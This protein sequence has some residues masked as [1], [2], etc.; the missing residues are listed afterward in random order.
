MTLLHNMEET[1]DTSFCTCMLHY[2][3]VN[4]SRR[5]RHKAVTHRHYD[6]ASLSTFHRVFITMCIILALC[7]GDHGQ[8][9]YEQERIFL[10][11][12][13]GI[14]EQ[15]QGEFIKL[16]VYPKASPNFGCDGQ[17]VLKISFAGPYRMARFFLDYY[18][19]PRNW[20]LDISDSPGGD[21][22]GGDGDLTSNMAE[23]QI[24]DKQMR[25]YSNGL[26]GYT[27]ETLNGGLLLKIVDDVVEAGTKLKLEIADEKVRWNNRENSKGVM[28][29]R[30][31]FMLNGQTP[32]YGEMDH[33][34]YVGLNR[35]PS[36]TSRTG[37][38][39]CRATIIMLSERDPEP[40]TESASLLLVSRA[41]EP[42]VSTGNTEINQCN[43]GRHNCR[44]NE[45]CTQT[46]K[47]FRCSCIHGYNRQGITCRDVDEC[48]VKSG[49][50]VHT[51]INTLGSY[52]CGCYFGFTLHIEGK[53]CLDKDECASGEHRCQHEC[54]NTIGSYECAC[55]KGMYLNE[56][57]RTC[58]NDAGCLNPDLDCA[59]YCVDVAN[60]QSICQC[61]PGYL[62]SG[63]KNC[64]PTCLLGNGGCQHVCTDSPIGPLCSCH[65]KY[66]L[67]TDGRTC[68]E[69]YDDPDDYSSTSAL[70]ADEVLGPRHNGASLSGIETCGLNNGG[71]DRECED[72]PTG[73]QCSCPEGFDLLAD[74]R[75]CNDRDEC[76]V[77]NGG[78]SHMCTNRLG[79]Y[80]CTCPRGYKL[81]SE[82][83]TCEDV[84]ECSMN[85]TCDHTCVNLPG[86]FRC[87]CDAGFQAYG[88]THC[89]DVDECSINN[90]GCQHGC[91]NTQ[92]SYECYCREGFK[93]HPNKKDCIAA[94]RCLPLRT[95]A[96][97][98]LQCETEGTDEVC[99]L[100]CESNSHFTASGQG[101][102]NYQCGESTHFEWTHGATNDT[103][104]SCSASVDVPMVS[105]KARLFFSTS[106]CELQRRVTRQLSKTINQKL[107][108]GGCRRDCE[109]S[110][111]N[112]SCDQQPVARR[113]RQAGRLSSSSSSIT[114]VA[115]SG[116]L[117]T[118]YVE[119]VIKAR[120]N[121]VT[122]R[123]DLECV[124]K[125]SERKMKR[126]ITKL[127]KAIERDHFV[128]Q[129]DG[130]EYEMSRNLNVTDVSEASCPLGHVMID[131]GRCVACSMGTYYH[132]SSGG[133][134]PC[135][136]GSYQ[137]EEGQLECRRC[138]Q[139]DQQ[140]DV[141]GAR[142]ITE[143][144]G[145]CRPGEYSV[146]GFQPCDSCPVGSY[147]PESGRTH[148]LPCKGGL[149]TR[150]HGSTSFADCLAKEHCG[151]GT[152]Y[153]VTTHSCERCPR[154][155]YQPHPA[156]NYCIRCPGN[157]TT[158]EN[159]VAD[160]DQCKDTTCR[161][162]IGQYV[163]Y[164]ETPN[165][166]GDYPANVDCTWHIKPPRGRKVIFV[167]SEIFLRKEDQC[168]DIVVIR[169]TASPYSTT[170]F[171]TCE[172]VTRPIAFLAQ[173]KR[174][175]IRFTT[176]AAHAAKG[177][178][179]HYSMY[180]ETYEDL[181]KD[182]VGD[183]RLYESEYH[184]EILKNKEVLAALLEIIAHPEI[185][186]NYRLEE[187]RSILPRSF[188]KLLRN[189][190]ARFLYPEEMYP[191]GYKDPLVTAS[192]WD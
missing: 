148:C 78:C 68:V 149:L 182:I 41:Q 95:P 15:G 147:Q 150:S 26:S 141:T 45:A 163:G 115:G 142:H 52:Q 27:S 73:V 169:K 143:C 50:C 79:T 157:T 151:P 42:V 75:T 122:S 110:F 49:G 74:G 146:D 56:D 186:D 64:I 133:C 6:P 152:Y 91:H 94:I 170:S 5:L 57:G 168:G 159:G 109:V 171:E 164:I 32:E 140:Y 69:A 103:L 184:Q 84:N 66:N 55:P 22:M 35:V 120:L 53:D 131:A 104:P 33:D 130:N 155:W 138:P 38:G 114:D 161:A 11:L 188:I 59:H 39:L 88:I 158:D 25:V 173:S 117:I 7:H 14:V 100:L 178:R 37:S 85:D 154:G 65:E 118:A 162:Q 191:N 8:S 124:R 165:F 137:D 112:L 4:L 13:T 29:S 126:L 135:E 192:T 98:I 47:S 145:Q 187:S 40:T 90:G 86:N 166:P 129:I 16:L 18:E 62:L 28:E 48:Q 125:K 43:D 60:G 44:E 81:T 134:L 34:I 156:M 92:G 96:R 61:R 71:C 51:C 119:I 121:G 174:V 116:S 160:G 89:G 23:L 106:R 102:F 21:G 46:R 20:T 167:V 177:F 183:G 63:S 36:S 17:A 111:L 99:S 190:V 128:V 70:R 19:P 10:D 24:R 127:R 123:C 12:R 101:T 139:Q 2:N 30:Y 87:L 136:A 176:D 58:S 105:R 189:K 77:D 113:K 172:N 72:T 3:S 180:D 1:G 93:L 97:A 80:E 9:L 179:I 83:H 54:I 175:W 108:A 132:A 181:M 107:S 185:Y 153:N 82:G 144:G 67:H 31:L 76:I